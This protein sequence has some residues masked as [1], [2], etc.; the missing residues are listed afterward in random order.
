M[1]K[2]YEPWLTC[3]GENEIFLSNH[4][5]YCVSDA[6]NGSCTVLTY[7][8]YDVLPSIPPHTYFCRQAYL[9]FSLN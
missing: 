3:F 8:E 5:D 6:I 1:P 4:K 2:K 9:P 7:D